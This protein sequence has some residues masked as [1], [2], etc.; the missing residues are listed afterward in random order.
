LFSN[1]ALGGVSQ[2]RAPLPSRPPPRTEPTPAQAP[3]PPE[4]IAKPITG[5][6]GEPRAT[7]AEYTGAIEAP[8]PA[9]A[10]VPKDG[11]TVDLVASSDSK[12]VPAASVTFTLPQ[13]LG[14]LAVLAGLIVGPIVGT[15]IWAA[16]QVNSL[17]TDEM[18]D[19]AALRA[20]TVSHADFTEMK[21]QLTELKGQIAALVT[22][23]NDLKVEVAKMGV[24]LE[25]NTKAL[26]A[27]H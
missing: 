22:S 7:L 21:G 16:T 9:A 23:V 18:K 11:A 1:H 17:R 14:A 4:P 20:D 12:T 13:I 24:R 26:E 5:T 6:L 19:I 27:K 15:V 10:H 2:G 25:Q 8:A 3:A